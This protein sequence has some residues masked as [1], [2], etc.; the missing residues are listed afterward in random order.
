MTDI[1]VRMI[2]AE[3]TQMATRDKWSNI[4]ESALRLIDLYEAMILGNQTKIAELK[5][6]VEEL[7]TLHEG[8]QRAIEAIMMQW[9]AER[10]ELKAH[11]KAVDEVNEK[12][13]C[14]GNCKKERN[15]PE[16]LAVHMSCMKCKNHSEWEMAE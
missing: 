16:P 11:C 2:K 1:E 9:K 15:K 5:E 13:K 8:D 12:M 4:C 10:N 3:L 14:C 7:K 6:E